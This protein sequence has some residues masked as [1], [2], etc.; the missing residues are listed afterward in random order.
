M[1]LSEILKI[2]KSADVDSFF[3]SYLGYNL[4]EKNLTKEKVE[5]DFK[6]IGGNES[7]ASNIDMLQEGEKGIVERITNAIDAVIER[8]KKD[9]NIIAAN[10][11]DKIVHAAF[12][13]YFDNKTKIF[14]GEDFRNN[15]YDAANQVVVAVNDGNKSTTPTF[16]IIDKGIGISGADFAKT[17][18][19]LQGGNK[20]KSDKN[21]LIGA[22][23]QGGSTSL[24]FASATIIIS[25]YNGQLYFTIV[26]AVELKGYKNHSYIYLTDK[27]GGVL[28]LENDIISSESDYLQDFFKSES[29]TFI[30]MVDAEIT[31]K[32]RDNDVNKPRSLGDYLNTEL[33]GVVFLY[34]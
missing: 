15:A 3:N 8:K 11:A 4:S 21:Y 16:D 14:N 24:S 34:I 17:I 12:P 18:L 6:F 20:I 5:K 32:F 9:K 28:T 25:K 29:G 26:K 7:N 13:K 23:G 10:D 27:N 2:Y 19:S 30:R 31:K 1:N 22:F 33:F